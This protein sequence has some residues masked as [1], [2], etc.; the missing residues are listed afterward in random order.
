MAAPENIANCC[1]YVGDIS[2]RVWN[3]FGCEN[4]T[5]FILRCRVYKSGKRDLNVDV[6][7]A[8]VRGEGGERGEN[9]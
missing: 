3:S 5:R 1:S 9:I 7:Y 4:S 6:L 8:G 2:L